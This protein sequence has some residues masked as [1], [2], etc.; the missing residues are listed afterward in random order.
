MNRKLSNIYVLQMMEYIFS[1]MAFIINNKSNKT[2]KNPEDNQQFSSC[3]CSGNR[4][5]EGNQQS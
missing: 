2:D 3:K 5:H 4:S 1:F